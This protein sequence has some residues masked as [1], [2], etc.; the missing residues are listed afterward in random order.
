MYDNEGK[1][2]TS[3]TSKNKEK[4]VMVILVFK[5]AGKTSVI[6]LTN[7]R[8]QQRILSRTYP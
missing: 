6:E 2:N 1:E 7:A 4:H 5:N 3:S 8:T